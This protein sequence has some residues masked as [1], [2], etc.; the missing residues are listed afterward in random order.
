MNNVNVGIWDR[1][2][3]VVVFLLFIAG[4]IGLFF[5]Y[6]P[7]IKQNQ[8]YREALLDLDRKIEEQER[9]GRYLKGSIEAVQKDPRTLERHARERLGYARSNEIVIQFVSPEEPPHSSPGR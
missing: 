3:R 7:L 6:L 8:K 1:L 5:W 9:Y 4:L 2:T